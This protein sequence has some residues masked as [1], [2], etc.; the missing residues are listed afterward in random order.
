MEDFLI[1]LLLGILAHRFYIYVRVSMLEKRLDKKV[2][3]VLTEFRKS[4]I[5]SRVEHVN[6]V[7]YLYNRDT[8]EFIAQENT[9]DELE[10]AAKLKH[11]D[12]LFH[13][14]HSEL[15]E[16]MGAKDGSK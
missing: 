4:I 9:F 12:K 7:Y 8:N 1:G 16:L 13:V 11:P 6:S 14:P 10:K 5:K 3:E 2:E 15:M